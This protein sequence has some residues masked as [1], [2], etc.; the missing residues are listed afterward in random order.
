M[1]QVAKNQQMTLSKQLQAAT[2]ERETF[3]AALAR[4]K[5]ERDELEEKFMAAILEV[6][7]KANLKQLVLEKKLQAVRENLRD[8]EEEIRQLT[9]VSGETSGADKLAV[10]EHQQQVNDDSVFI[11]FHLPRFLQIPDVEFL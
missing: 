1:L 10:Q 6:Q 4:V 2:R 8:R 11:R 7:Q 3:E 9:S 5:G